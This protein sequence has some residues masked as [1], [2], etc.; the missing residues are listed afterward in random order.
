EDIKSN[1]FHFTLKYNLSSIEEKGLEARRGHHAELIEESDKVFFVE[2]LENFLILFDSWITV[3]KKI[4]ILFSDRKK[5]GISRES[6]KTHFV[7]KIGARA[8]R[9]RFFPMFLVDFYFWL[10][11]NSKSHIIHAYSIFDEMLENCVILNLALTPNEDFSYDDVDEIKGRG[12][13]RRHLITLGYSLKYSDMESNHMDS[14]NMHT[15][16]GHGVSKDK[17]KLCT[18]NGTTD[19][20]NI[21]SF[22][23]EKSDIDLE[24]ICPNLVGYLKDRDKKIKK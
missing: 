17:I 23:I 12:F 15:K 19:I 4:P 16:S 2:G 13:R 3:Y 8:M 21:F 1:Y 10:I 14:W 6:Q 18:L 22:I 5:V 9:S 24:E 20:K 7:Y 11:R